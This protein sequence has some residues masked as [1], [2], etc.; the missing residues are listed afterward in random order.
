MGRVFNKICDDLYLY[1]SELDDCDENSESL[2]EYI[3]KSLNDW[4]SNHPKYFIFIE[5]GLFDNLLYNNRK[6]AIVSIINYLLIDDYIYNEELKK[7][8]VYFLYLAI[9]SHNL[10]VV[11]RLINTYDYSFA[12]FIIRTEFC[13]QF[14]EMNMLIHNNIIYDDYNIIINMNYNNCYDIFDIINCVKFTN[15]K[16]KLI[17]VMSK[18]EENIPEEIWKLI[19]NYL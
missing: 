9:Y 14:H 12:N 11:K 13:Y 17:Y 4:K 2:I 1:S 6:N 15:N 5:T 8:Q 18:L 10:S 19:N 7:M 3:K 16:T